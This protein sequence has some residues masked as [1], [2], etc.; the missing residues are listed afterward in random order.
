MR[1][2]I[3]HPFETQAFRTKR[4]VVAATIAQPLG[5]QPDPQVAENQGQGHEQ[6]SQLGL[7]GAGVNFACS[8]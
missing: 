5:M 4:Q 3:E 7:A 2:P 1:Q 8:S 6:Q